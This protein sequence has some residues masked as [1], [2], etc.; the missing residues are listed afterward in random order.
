MCKR[1]QTNDCK[2]GDGD[3]DEIKA[4]IIIVMMTMANTKI[5]EVGTSVYEGVEDYEVAG[6][7]VD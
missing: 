2:R 7:P 5:C 1:Q 4:V 6:Q 3:D